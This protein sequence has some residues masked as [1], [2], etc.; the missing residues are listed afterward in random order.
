MLNLPGAPLFPA[1]CYFLEKGIDGLGPFLPVRDEVV[2][3]GTFL[4][5][6]LMLLN[7]LQ[8]SPKPAHLPLVVTAG[9][10]FAAH[11]VDKAFW[12]EHGVGR[13]LCSIIERI[14]EIDPKVF[15]RITM[16]G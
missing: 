4:F 13:R 16:A 3:K 11:P 1:K 2:Q 15:M 10:W 8:V 5:V 14:I 7:L 6:A 12:V 9:G